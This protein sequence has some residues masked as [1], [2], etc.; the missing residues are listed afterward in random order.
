MAGHLAGRPKETEGRKA[1]GS[2]EDLVVEDKN[3]EVSNE[4]QSRISEELSLSTRQW[5][6][7]NPA[8]RV[9][10]DEIPPLG[11]LGDY[12]HVSDIESMLNDAER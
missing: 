12:D 1:E 8:K 7:P 4:D 2:E 10:G 9:S 3:K 5:T 11:D 6:S